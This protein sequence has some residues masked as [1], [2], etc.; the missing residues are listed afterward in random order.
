MRIPRCAHTPQYRKQF[1]IAVS[2]VIRVVAKLRYVLIISATL[3]LLIAPLAAISNVPAQRPP[4]PPPQ[5]PGE[6]T[7]VVVQLVQ[8]VVVVEVTSQATDVVPTILIVSPSATS[9]SGIQSHILTIPSSEMTAYT[10]PQTP[11]PSAETGSAGMD[12]I[13]LLTGSIAMLAAAAY[14]TFEGI[15]RSNQTPP[16]P[17]SPDVSWNPMTWTPSNLAEGL[18]DAVGLPEEAGDTLESSARAPRRRKKPP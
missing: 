6:G 1:M 18:S 3:F 4:P 17:P 10:A 5:H 16:P 9:D 7:V 14:L 12:A 11:L 8:L 13:G 2:D 15:K